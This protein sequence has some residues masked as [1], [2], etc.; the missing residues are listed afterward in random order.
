VL[1]RKERWER[2]EMCEV[3]SK[4]HK[5][6]D[7]AMLHTLYVLCAHKDTHI[8]KTFKATLIRSRT[9]VTDH[10]VIHRHIREPIVCVHSCVFVRVCSF[11]C[12]RSCVFVQSS[13]QAI[14]A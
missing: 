3:V 8:I 9:V 6:I 7:C 2:R 12:V 1:E 5:D 14:I 10:R 4:E 13:I 11:V